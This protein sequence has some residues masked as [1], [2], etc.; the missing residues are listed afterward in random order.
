MKRKRIH[1][2]FD[3]NFK[4]LNRIL[5]G[6][7]RPADKS[8]FASKNN[9]GVK[10]IVK[11]IGTMYVPETGTYNASFPRDKMISYMWKRYIT[12]K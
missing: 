2:S 7:G 1:L 9:I 10:Y 11:T 5:G 4:I 6:R 8:H 3:Q 12:V